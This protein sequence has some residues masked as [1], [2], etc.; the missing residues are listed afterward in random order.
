[1]ISC[2]SEED[3]WW[4][5]A[6]TSWCNGYTA[7][8]DHLVW[9]CMPVVYK[10]QAH[11]QGPGIWRSIF[12]RAATQPQDLFRPWSTLEIYIEMITE[13][14][15]WFWHNRWTHAACFDD[16]SVWHCFV[17]KEKFNIMCFHW[18]VCVYKHW[19]HVVTMCLKV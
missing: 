7:F 18:D 17:V 13:Y 12:T 15:T 2:I 10:C 19:S 6:I 3:G 5:T 9:K 8:A 1:M 16:M 14:S 4:Q 11:V